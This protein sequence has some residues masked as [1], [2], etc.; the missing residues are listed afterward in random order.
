LVKIIIESP[1]G[2]LGEN[3]PEVNAEPRVGAAVAWSFRKKAGKGSKPVACL[4]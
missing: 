4:S 3:V 2:E 1:S